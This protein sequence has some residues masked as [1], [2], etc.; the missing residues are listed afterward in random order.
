MDAVIEFSC[1]VACNVTNWVDIDIGNV[2][3]SA[4]MSIKEAREAFLPSPSLSGMTN[5]I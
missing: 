4:L 3:G 2:S 5:E 1:P